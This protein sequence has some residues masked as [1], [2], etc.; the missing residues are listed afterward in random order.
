MCGNVLLL[1]GN[2]RLTGCR[3]ETLI[4]TPPSLCRQGNGNTYRPCARIVREFP[5]LATGFTAVWVG[6]LCP[7]CKE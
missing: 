1:V 3:S 5:R 6:P 7:K 2:C 4:S